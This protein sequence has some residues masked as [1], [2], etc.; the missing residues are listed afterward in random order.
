MKQGRVVKKLIFALSVLFMILVGC[1]TDNSKLKVPNKM[2]SSGTG[3]QEKLGPGFYRVVRVID[4]DTI[5]IS[6]KGKDEKLRFIG[7]NTPETRHPEK[8]AEPYGF[9]AAEYTKKLLDNQPVRIKFDIEQRDKYGRLLAYVY[10]SD[11]TFVNARLLKEGYA[12][13]MTVPPN[14]KYAEYF[15]H[16]EKEAREAEKGLWGIFYYNMDGNLEME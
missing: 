5:E 14:V 8:G 16:L 7:I 11:G 1:T 13:V 3:E 2:E 15:V 10:L 6:F 4:G 9:E 12:Q